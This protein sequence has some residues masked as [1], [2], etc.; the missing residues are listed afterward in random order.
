MSNIFL[1]RPVFLPVL[2]IICW[3]K[4]QMNTECSLYLWVYSCHVVVEFCLFRSFICKFHN[5]AVEIEAILLDLRSYLFLLLTNLYLWYVYIPF[6]APCQV[7]SIKV[8]QFKFVFLKLSKFTKTFQLYCEGCYLPRDSKR[9]MYLQ[10][11][12]F[13][14]GSVG[15]FWWL[16]Y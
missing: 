15:C 1:W 16:I 8:K 5:C 3:N 4:K 11:H 14:T 7:K 13:R 10:S 9:H 2:F 6:R 12:S